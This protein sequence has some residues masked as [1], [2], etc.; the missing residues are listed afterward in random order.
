[1]TDQDSQT[2]DTV[3]LLLQTE[4]FKIDKKKLIK[5]SQY[6]AMLL[7]TTYTDHLLS[8]HIINYEI[9][10]ISFQVS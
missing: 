7:S 4:R 6:F 9:P 1:M 8:E 3:T 5:K 10:S 2:E